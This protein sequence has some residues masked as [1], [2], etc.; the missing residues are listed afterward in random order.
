MYPTK[1]ETV[2]AWPKPENLTDV[3]SFL[4]FANFYRQFIRAYSSIVRPMTRLTEKNIKFSWGVEEQAAFDELK[5][6]FTNAPVLRRFDHDR[7]VIVET[8][9]SD[10]V[11]TGVLSQYDDAGILHP[12]AFFSKKHSPAECNYEV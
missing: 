11:S 5:T 8:D 10:Y 4:G 3:R 7:D 2:V 12:V 9:V 1:V 6:A